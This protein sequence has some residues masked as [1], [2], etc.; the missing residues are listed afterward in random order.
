MDD[1]RVLRGISSLAW[2]LSVSFETADDQ[3]KEEANSMPKPLARPSHFWL[4]IRVFS[5]AAVLGYMVGVKF[6]CCRNCHP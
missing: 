1:R 3:I 5:I 6:T 2:L 4:F